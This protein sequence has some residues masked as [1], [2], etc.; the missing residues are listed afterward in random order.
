MRSVSSGEMEGMARTWLNK[1]ITPTVVPKARSA[2]R[3]GRRAAKMEPKMS[4]ST[5]N[6]SSTPSP[7]LLKDWL[8]AFSASGP[9]TATVSPSPEVLVTALTKF[10][11]SVFEMFWVC[12]SKLTWKNPT[13]WSLLM[14]GPVGSLRFPSWSYG[15][16]TGVTLGSAL[17]LSTMVLMR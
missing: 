5:I 10:L 15:L 7:V 14:V 2:E 1:P 3:I 8:L 9:V 17:I 13:V 4:S 12:L 16:V 11:A 6:A